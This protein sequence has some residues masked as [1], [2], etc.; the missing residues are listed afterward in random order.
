MLPLSLFR[1]RVISCACLVSSMSQGG[2]FLIFYYLPTWFQAV[3][4]LGPTASGVRTLP[5]V[6]SMGLSTLVTGVLSKFS[7]S[8]LAACY[9]LTYYSLEDWLLYPIHR[10]RRC[11]I[12]GISWSP[13]YTYAI[14][15]DRGL[16]LLSTSQWCCIG[17]DKAVA[18]H[19]SSSCHF[20]RSTCSG[21]I[22]SH[23]LLSPRLGFVHLFWPNSVCEFVKVRVGEVRTGS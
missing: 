8:L 17:D 10:H 5:S 20:K 2:F 13:N 15:G 14:F 21:H 18:D 6:V 16:G 1:N 19:S 12:S 3:K 11:W 7:K 4:S 23:F 9:M 22:A